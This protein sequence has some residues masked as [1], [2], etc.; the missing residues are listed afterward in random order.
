MPG[1][2]DW[3]LKVSPR[4]ST[5]RTRTTR[6][7]K[8]TSMTLTDALAHHPARDTFDLPELIRAIEACQQCASLCAVCADSD[9]A[10]DDAGMHGCIRTCLDCSAVCAVTATILSRPTPSGDAWEALV[11]ACIASCR[12][13]AVECEKHDHVCCQAC[14]KACREC[15]Q[16][17]QQLLAAAA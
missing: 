9:L 15:E 8:G 16:A 13:C 2:T 4:R 7:P 17:L 10:R 14:A 6:I 12:E 1:V 5:G 11:R 3:S